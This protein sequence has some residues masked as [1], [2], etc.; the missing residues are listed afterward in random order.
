MAKLVA[1]RTRPSRLVAFGRWWKDGFHEAPVVMSITTFLLLVGLAA[2]YLQFFTN[3]MSDAL[4]PTVSLH[5]ST[6]VLQL[7]QSQTGVGGIDPCFVVSH[8]QAQAFMGTLHTFADTN[9]DYK[10]DQARSCIYTSAPAT[11]HGFAAFDGN[12]TRAIQVNTYKDSP[13]ETFTSFDARQ[14]TAR[15]SVEEN[16]VSIDVSAQPELKGVTAAFYQFAPSTGHL[17]G[18][19]FTLKGVTVAIW[20]EPATQQDLLNIAQVAIMNLS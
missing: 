12:G 2:F 14:R 7:P 9:V 11:Q 5:R 4:D 17:S 19:T 18:I 20:M 3:V 8:T 6:H 10:N 15:F 13:G 1:M 16:Y